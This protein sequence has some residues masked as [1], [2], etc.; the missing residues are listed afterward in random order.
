MK[1]L[2]NPIALFLILACFSFK[3]FDEEVQKCFIKVGE[4]I[5]FSNKPDGT[6]SSMSERK[7]AYDGSGFNLK[8]DTGNNMI[9]SNITQSDGPKQDEF[10]LLG[11]TGS[12]TRSEN[13]LTLDL[14]KYGRNYYLIHLESSAV[15]GTFDTIVR[16]ILKSETAQRKPAEYY[17]Q[18]KDRS[19]VHKKIAIPKSN[20]LPTEQYPSANDVPEIRSIHLTAVPAEIT[21]EELYA[22]KHPSNTL[23]HF[24]KIE[25]ELKGGKVIPF[26]SG[27]YILCEGN[28]FTLK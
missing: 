20:G 10:M 5:S 2:K 26:P 25:I 11:C 18:E 22:S 15:V 21:K 16:V 12:L 3:S 27:S 24:T 1:T 13:N 19:G 17:C 14:T 8:I 28:S 6:K 4:T 23:A 9:L 7:G